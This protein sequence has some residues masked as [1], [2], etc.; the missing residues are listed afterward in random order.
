VAY[1]AQ[2]TSM[3]PILKTLLHYSLYGWLDVCMEKEPEPANWYYQ[4]L[5][6]ENGCILLGM[7]I[8]VPTTLHHVIQPHTICLC[9]VQCAK[10][11]HLDTEDMV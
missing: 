2:D 10:L 3:G 11:L 4:E 1:V 5:L 6:S 7:N 8:I 9:F